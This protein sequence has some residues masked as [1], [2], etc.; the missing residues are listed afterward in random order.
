MNSIV[1]DTNSS[2]NNEF[3]GINLR[4]GLLDLKERLCNF[5][6]VSDFGKIHA[7]DLDSGDLASGVKH[8]FEEL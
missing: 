3:T 4:L 8:G 6:V 7:L 5:R 1:D 2:V